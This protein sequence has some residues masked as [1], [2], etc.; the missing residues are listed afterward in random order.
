LS[1]MLR[2]TARY[3]DVGDAAEMVRPSLIL[4]GELRALRLNRAVSPAVAEMVVRLELR[5]SREPK[6]V[7]AGTL[8]E[9]EPLDEDSG[10]G[11]ARAANRA[12][13]RLV[14][15]AAAEMAK[16]TPDAPAPPAE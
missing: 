4:T 2:A 15:R 3:A 5:A 11:F 13:G 7:W 16:A 10:A 9:T 8:V 6:A 14:T 12:A 1:D